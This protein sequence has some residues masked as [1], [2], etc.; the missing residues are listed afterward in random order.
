MFSALDAFFSTPEVAMTYFKPTLDARP[1]R[2][3]L[4]ASVLEFKGEWKTIERSIFIDKKIDLEALI[5]ILNPLRHW[6][7]NKV[8]YNVSL[9]NAD[10]IARF[11]TDLY[12]SKYEP[13]LIERLKE[14]G[15]DTTGRRR[16][17]R[18]VKR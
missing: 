12:K 9:H 6:F 17:L 15:L 18:E 8:E 11:D 16:A 4:S 10:K 3:D 5:R 2:V 7:Y 13:Y 14:A 1:I